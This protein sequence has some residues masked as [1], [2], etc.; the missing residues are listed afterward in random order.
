MRLPPLVSSG[1]VLH[2]ALAM[3]DPYL[4]KLKE[5]DVHPRASGKDWWEECSGRKLVTLGHTVVMGSRIA[6]ASRTRC[7]SE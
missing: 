7:R 3:L 5:A 1:G 4:E 6:F 2:P